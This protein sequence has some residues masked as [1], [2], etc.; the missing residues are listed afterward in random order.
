MSR[1]RRKRKR[2]QER[3]GDGNQSVPLEPDRALERSSD[4]AGAEV[5]TSP[6]ASPER[7]VQITHTRSVEVSAG[8]LPHPAHFQAYEHAQPGAADRILT[9]AERQQEHRH[10]QQ[11][12][13]LNSDASREKRGQWLA[14]LV[15]ILALVGGMFLAYFDKSLAGLTAMILPIAT[16]IG[17]FVTSKRPRPVA[18]QPDRNRQHPVPQDR[19]PTPD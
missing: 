19:P 8:P 14:F 15:T 12:A 2:A 18:S 17:I 9:M 1:R 7:L 3:S 10:A 11:I 13:R 5:G 4:D 6:R 16:I